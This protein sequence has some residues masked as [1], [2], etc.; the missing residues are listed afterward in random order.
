MFRI[1]LLMFHEN[2]LLVIEK[3]VYSLRKLQYH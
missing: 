2:E 3:N 1:N